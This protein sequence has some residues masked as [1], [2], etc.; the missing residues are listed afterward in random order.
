ASALVGLVA[1]R[2]AY[3][4]QSPLQIDVAL[5]QSEQLALAQARVQRGGDERPIF[6]AKLCDQPRDLV[7]LEE[8]RRTL[9]H[10]PWLRVR[11]RVLAVNQVGPACAVKRGADHR[12]ELVY[13]CGP[14]ALLRPVL[15]EQLEPPGCER[16]VGS[17]DDVGAL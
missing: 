10:F 12:A 2:A 4:E 9:R 11:R 1:V 6:A 13:R 15:Q 7:R 8:R 3:R 16:D 14:Q 5:L 17:L